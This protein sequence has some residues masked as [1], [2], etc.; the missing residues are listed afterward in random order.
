MR[1]GR[2]RIGTTPEVVAN[3]L[4]D[5][6]L[7]AGGAGRLQEAEQKLAGGGFQGRISRVRGTTPY[8]INV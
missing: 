5:R 6:L 2:D 4:L 3:E 1:I 8:P 7:V